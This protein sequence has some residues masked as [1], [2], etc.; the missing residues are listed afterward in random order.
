[1]R[2][3]GLSWA[4]TLTVLAASSC[5]QAQ[6]P[7]PDWVIRSKVVF[8]QSQA[9]PEAHPQRPLERFRVVFPYIA[10]DLFGQPTTGDFF[11]VTLGADYGFE[12]DLNRTHGS[13][14]ASLQ[15][16]EFGESYLRIEPADARLAR[17]APM[18]LQADGIEPTGR[19]QWFDPDSGRTL[20][21]LYF[22]R[23][24]SITGRTRGR[25]RMLRYAIRTATPGYVWVGP[26]A[27]ADEDIYTV[28][29][30]PARP[31]LLVTPLPDEPP[32]VSP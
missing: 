24:A 23:P 22:D 20:W 19:T 3:R 5:G 4:L 28:M 27:G 16:T 8:S 2:V 6:K 11:N 26:Q 1:M 17:L 15:P 32:T 9:H 29:P 10:G 25:E 21:L 18:V 30:R 31:L 13:L 7:N 12:I 14:L